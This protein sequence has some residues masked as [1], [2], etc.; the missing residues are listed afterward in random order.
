MARAAAQRCRDRDEGVRHEAFALLGRLP[1][2]CLRRSLHLSDWQGLL[3]CGLA[4]P[5]PSGR[6]TAAGP[7]VGGSAGGG[8]SKPASRH[9]AAIRD[10]ASELLLGYL[11]SSDGGEDEGSGGGEGASQQEEMWALPEEGGRQAAGQATPPWQ[12]RL[13]LLLP[14]ELLELDAPGA[15]RLPSGPA[16]AAA[17]QH[18]LAAWRGALQEGLQPEQLEV[19]GLGTVGDGMLPEEAATEAE[20]GADG[21]DAPWAAGEAGGELE[22]EWD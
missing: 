3:D 9:A 8:R 5:M 12:R 11:G 15:P 14:P 21:R 16:A 7:S 2:P 6:S 4:G 20:E 18:L 1:L 19:L 10:A 17:A 22:R 13:Q